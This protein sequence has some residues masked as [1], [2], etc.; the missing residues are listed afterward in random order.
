MRAITALRK[1]WPEYCIEAWALGMFMISASV[2]TVLFESQGAYLRL[3]IPNADIRRALIG[4][5]MGLTAVILIYSP[6]GRRSGAHMNPAVTLAFWRLGKISNWGAFYYTLA[7]CV[8]GLLG[9]LVV[10]AV[11]G[12]A[13]TTAPVSFIATTPGDAGAT[14]AFVAE[15][16][17]S[18][19]LMCVVLMVSGSRRYAKWTGWCAG[20]LVAVYITVEAPLSGMSMNPARSLASA[21]PAGNWSSFWIYLVAPVLGMQAAAALFVRR[22]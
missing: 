4:V 20:L 18:A 5:A 22:A 10:E 8:G 16:C 15:L 6:W 11:C 3:A 12:D 17:I 9:V 2:F 7:Q 14:W 21:W 13:F 19:L 1:H